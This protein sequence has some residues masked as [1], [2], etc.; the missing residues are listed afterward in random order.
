MTQDLHAAKPWTR[1]SKWKDTGEEQWNDWHWQMRNALRT[2]EELMEALPLSGEQEQGVRDALG[3][4]RMAITP[5]YASLIDPDDEN[6]PI[7]LQ[8]IPRGFEAVEHPDDHLDPL[9]EDEDSPAPGITHRY[10]DRVLFLVTDICSMYCRHCTRRRMVGDKDNH[11]T[12]DQYQGAIE[13]IRDNPAIR[14]V[15]ISGGDPLTRSDDHIEEILAALRE[16]D[17]VEI[18]RIGTRTPVVM[19]MRITDDLV[20]MLRKYHPVYVNTHF[21]HPREIT[22]EAAQAT[23]RL[24]DAGI[25]VA[26]QSVLLRYVNDCSHVMKELVQRLLAIRV[27]PYYVYQCDLSM[28]IRHFRTPV[29]RG[30][31]IIESLRGHT[32]GMAVPTFVV[33]APGGG[34]KIPVMPNYILSHDSEHIILRNFEGTVCRYDENAEVDSGCGHHAACGDPRFQAKDGPAGMLEKGGR[35]TLETGSSLRHDRYNGENDN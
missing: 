9:H 6:C 11:L 2:P 15:L 32:S 31:R 35:Q 24:A 5:Y 19:P 23:A 7:G 33:D 13:Y 14:D 10:P 21:N 34:G 17:H 25:P 12:R 1:F 28:G 8:A 20:A 27:R 16:I 30:I 3:R 29:A 4:F 26:N 18:I 22:P